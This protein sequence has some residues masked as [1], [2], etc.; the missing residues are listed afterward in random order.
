VKALPGWSWAQKSPHKAGKVC[1]LSLGIHFNSK[2][3][4]ESRLSSREVLF[5]CA[6][7]SDLVLLFIL[8]NRANHYLA[9]CNCNPC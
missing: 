3:L 5:L 2:S 4:G 8:A 7:D 9:L 1:R 6:L